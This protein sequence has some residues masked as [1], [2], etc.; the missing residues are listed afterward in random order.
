MSICCRN[1]AKLKQPVWPKGPRQRRNWEECEHK[2]VWRR[3][4][5]FHS[6]SLFMLLTKTT[7]RWDEIQALL[8]PGEAFDN[9]SCSTQLHVPPDR[10]ATSMD[11]VPFYW[12]QLRITIQKA[13]IAQIAP[14]QRCLISFCWQRRQKP[15]MTFAHVHEMLNVNL[16]WIKV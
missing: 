2:C 10:G 13:P 9:K 11:G 6:Y 14:P 1:L 15:W 3:W 12:I 8:H 7:Y 4:V 16:I 5:K